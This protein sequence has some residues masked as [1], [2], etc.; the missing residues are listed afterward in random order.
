[1][2]RNV[3]CLGGPFLPGCLLKMQWIGVGQHT[4]S[5]RHK[6]QHR[7]QGSAELDVIDL[8]LELRLAFNQLLAQYKLSQP[9]T[10]VF[11]KLPK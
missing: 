7:Q 4:D 8:G 9:A 3:S 2:M 11:F 1:M 5:K 10:Q 6:V